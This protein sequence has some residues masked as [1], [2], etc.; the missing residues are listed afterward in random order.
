VGSVAPLTLDL[1]ISLSM[2]ISIFEVQKRG[3]TDFFWA[4]CQKEVSQGKYVFTLIFLAF[5]HFS[6]FFS[7]LAFISLVLSQKGREPGAFICAKSV[8][9]L[10][11]VETLS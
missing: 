6:P 8:T 5:S 11:G 4:D 10:S 3:I 1:T 2:R 7:D 9:I